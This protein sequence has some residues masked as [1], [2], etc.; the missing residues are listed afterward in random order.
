MNYLSTD[1][2]IVYAFLLLT[3]FIGLWTGKNIKDIK[4]YAVTNKK[5]GT[6]LLLLTFLATNIGGGTLNSVS[7]VFTVGIIRTAAL[8]GVAASML[9]I[10]FLVIP[11]MHRFKT[12]IT[13]GDVMRS[14]YGNDSQLIT[15]I[16]GML[17]SISMVVLGI[18]VLGQIAEPLLGIRPVWGARLGALLLIAYT[19]YGGIKS[20]TTTDVFQ[21]L[22]LCIMIPFIASTA[23]REAGGISAVFSS[24]PPDHFKVLSHSEF[25]FYLTLFLMW[26]ILPVGITS[27]AIFQ[28][29][30]MA[31][32]TMHLKRQYL[33]AA[34]FDPLF[35]IT[36]LL[37]GL[38][39]LVL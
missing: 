1:H 32:N 39:A 29:L 30:L 26:S 23:V 34:G 20:V 25:P 16:L 14:L 35:R 4:E 15:G 13:I 31:K 17:Y 36:L 3:L 21:F 11:H 37:I 9:I 22:V 33:I 2:L 28:R 12:A 10:A 38:A 8:S 27:P 18:V 6:A 24:V 19:A 7:G 5:Y